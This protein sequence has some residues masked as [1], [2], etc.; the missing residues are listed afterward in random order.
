MISIEQQLLDVT[1]AVDH[2][3]AALLPKGE[4]IL[5]QAMRYSA[6]SA[7]KRL[8]PFMLVVTADIWGVERKYSLRAAAALEIIHSYSLIHD[9][10]PAMDNDDFR[11]GMPSCHKRF[12]EATAILA[13]DS[14]LSLAFEILADDNT[15]PDPG[16]RC[17]LVKILAENIGVNGMAG[18]QV[19]D[20]IY[21][22]QTRAEYKDMMKMQ[23]MKTARLFIASCLMGSTLGY[24]KYEE[25]QSLIKYAEAFGLAF[26]FIDDLED[27]SPQSNLS[28]NNIAK[29]L[30]EEKTRKHA[31]E[32]IDQAK[33]ELGFLGKK[34]DVL[35][36][37]AQ[38]LNN[39]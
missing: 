7:G 15:H 2:H 20:L 39:F 22:R 9:D 16:V 5:S 36:Q 26:Q 35:D 21:E 11:R 33:K 30:G 6:L 13:G 3:I 34:S 38:L 24:A 29:L 32:F 19:L 23:W 4:D 25:Q 10:L 18:G 28:N 8:R 17:Q 14:L 31:H 12:D 1:Q 37:L 27:I